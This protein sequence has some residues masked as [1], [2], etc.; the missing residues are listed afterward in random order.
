MAEQGTLNAKVQGST[1]WQPTSSF[2]IPS[3]RSY[4]IICKCIS[5]VTSR[6]QEWIMC[7][8]QFIREAFSLPLTVIEYHI[9]QSLKQLFPQKACIE[10]DG[11]NFDVENYA[12]AQ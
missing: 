7:N 3:P 11:G 6:E 1:P 10:V 2:L 12:S 4:M 9:S 8:E 5:H